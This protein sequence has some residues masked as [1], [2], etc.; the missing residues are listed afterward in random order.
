MKLQLRLDYAV[1]GKK[2]NANQ[3]IW[4]VIRT[5]FNMVN[6]RVRKPGFEVASPLPGSVTLSYFFN[7]F[8]LWEGDAIIHGVSTTSSCKNPTGC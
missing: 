3:N 7:S 8:E 4:N 6:F 1:W 2:G 5:V